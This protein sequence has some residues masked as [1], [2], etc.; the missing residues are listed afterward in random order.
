[1]IDDFSVVLPDTDD[2]YGGGEHHDRKIKLR[3]NVNWE[4]GPTT[5]WETLDAPMNMREAAVIF[6]EGQIFMGTN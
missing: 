6:I 5:V 3:G 4:A 1:M 2:E